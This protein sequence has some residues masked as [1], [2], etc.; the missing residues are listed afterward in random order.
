[1]TYDMF[2]CLKD[3][4]GPFFIQQIYAKHGLRHEDTDV[5]KVNE[6]PTLMERDDHC[7]NKNFNI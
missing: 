4:N 1:M 2:W 6:V 3:R 7:T 5:K